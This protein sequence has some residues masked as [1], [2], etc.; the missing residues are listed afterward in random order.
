MGGKSPSPAAT[1]GNADL[2]FIGTL[3]LKASCCSSGGQPCRDSGSISTTVT[4]SAGAFTKS[5]AYS[6]SMGPDSGQA[7]Q[8][9]ANAFHSDAASPV[10]AFFTTDESGNYV[11][12]LTARATG[13]ATNYPLST[14]LV[15]HYPADFPSPSFQVI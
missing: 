11:M 2:S 5:V 9:L 4:T 3:G 15:S 6:S 1:S 14:S 12:Y 7:V 10:D 13:P 8:A